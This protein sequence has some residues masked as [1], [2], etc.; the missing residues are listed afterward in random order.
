MFKAG[1]IVTPEG[2]HKDV[3]FKIHRSRLDYYWSMG[4]NRSDNKLWLASGE[5]IGLK[6]RG[7]WVHQFHLEDCVLYS[8][9]CKF[10]KVKK[11][12]MTE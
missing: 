12:S 4:G 6:Y 11:F 7:T 2:D 8:P 5:H 9:I 3:I 10:K 1:D